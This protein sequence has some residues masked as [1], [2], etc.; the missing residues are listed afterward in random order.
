MLS[1]NAEHN[2]PEQFFIKKRRK[3]YRYVRFA[4]S[5]LCFD[6]S[7]WT[8][9]PV[10]CLEVGAGT[11]LL[12]VEWATKNQDRSYIAMDVKSDR[13]QKGAYEAEARGLSNVQFLRTRADLLPEHIT[14]ASVAELWLTFPDPFPKKGSA[15]RR[16]THPTYLKIYQLL[17]APQGALFFKH[18]NPA[19]FQ[20][21]LEQLVHFGWHI[22]ELAF[23][24]HTSDLP[25]HYKIKTTYETRWHEE[26][27]T[28]HFVKATPPPTPVVDE[29]PQA[30]A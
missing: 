21:S 9:Q 6:D 10:D 19:F 3:K 26:G 29:A 16:L 4:N 25:E 30:N 13:L 15:G 2:D 24:L 12:S 20:W 11:G 8:P 17:L 5:A 18:D 23:N 7:A 1:A 14:P 22:N 28:T 27:R